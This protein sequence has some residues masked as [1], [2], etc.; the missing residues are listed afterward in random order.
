MKN[1][2]KLIRQYKDRFSEA[3]LWEKI[4]KY[5]KKAGIKTVYPVLLLYFAFL[6]KET[7]PR[8]KMVII[9]TLGYFIAPIDLIPDLNP[10]IGFND[11]FGLLSFALVLV[12]CYINDEVREKARKKLKKWFGDYDESQLAPIDNQL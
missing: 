12:S 10:I 6:R 5:G 2:L 11:D 8:A 1:P 9:G 7:N 3:E 4:K